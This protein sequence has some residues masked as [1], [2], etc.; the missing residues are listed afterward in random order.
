I[1]LGVRNFDLKDIPFRSR[2]G[3]KLTRNLFRYATGI[4]ITD[5]QTGLR[6]FARKHFEWLLSIKGEAFEYEL[7]MLAETKDAGITIH[8]VEIDTVYLNGNESS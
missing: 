7:N 6:L 2:F 5:T 8:E 1:I 4:G 3:N